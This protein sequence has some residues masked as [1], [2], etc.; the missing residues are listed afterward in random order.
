MTDLLKPDIDKS[1]PVLETVFP[2]GKAIEELEALEKMKDEDIDTSDIPEIKDF[3]GSVRGKY[4][5]KIQHFGE[6]VQHYDLMTVRPYLKANNARLTRK[7]YASTPIREYLSQIEPV[8]LS[9]KY[10]EFYDAHPFYKEVCAGAKHH[11]WW[12]GG[13]EDHVREMIGI[14]LDIHDLYCGEHTFSKSDIIIVC[15]LHDFDKIWGYT[16][17]T[18]EDR[19]KN[20]KKFKDQQIFRV[21][22]GYDRILDGYSLKLLELARFGI[23]P[24]NEQW[25]AVMFHEGGY[26]T[27]NFGWGGTTKTAQSINSNNHLAPFIHMLDIYSASILGK[28]IA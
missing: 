19:A 1:A 12:K 28:S 20:P 13:L 17:I 14:G 4:F 7:R 21:K 10:L 24:T 16:Y 3:S 22:E 8:E 23:V 9:E 18:N 15:F 2:H 6:K 5:G 27:A 25:S 11:H 26:S